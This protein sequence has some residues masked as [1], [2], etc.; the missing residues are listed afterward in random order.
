MN[1]A[2]PLSLHDLLR[3]IYVLSGAKVQ[4]IIKKE[5]KK[6]EKLKLKVKN[7]RENTFDRR[8]K[9]ELKEKKGRI[10]QAKAKKEKS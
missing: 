1:R 6:K 9:V 10:A 8:S 3:P 4:L 5:E 2:P 7:V